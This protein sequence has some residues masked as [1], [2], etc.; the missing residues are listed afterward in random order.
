MTK[1]LLP[2]SRLYD[3]AVVQLVLFHLP[4]SKFLYFTVSRLS[5]N[6]IHSDEIFCIDIFFFFFFVYTQI[7]IFV[8]PYD[9]PKLSRSSVQ[10][11]RF[12]NSRSPLHLF[13]HA[14]DNAFGVYLTL[15]GYIVGGM[16]IPATHINKVSSALLLPPIKTL[17]IEKKR[18]RGAR[19]LSKRD[20]DA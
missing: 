16:Q 1:N 3:F 8:L 18:Q 9:S 7:L 14:C 11:S 15:R 13:A 6:I 20:L 19:L 5:T 17:L 2:R 12:A 10:I 4:L